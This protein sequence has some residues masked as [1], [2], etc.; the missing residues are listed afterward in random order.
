[1]VFSGYTSL[2]NLLQFCS[3]SENVELSYFLA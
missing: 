2:E 3:G 1:M